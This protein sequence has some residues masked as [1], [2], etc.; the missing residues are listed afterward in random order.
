VYSVAQVACEAR[1]ARS[2]CGG[3]VLV[4]CVCVCVCVF[5]RYLT[6]SCDARQLQLA[7]LGE[8]GLPEIVDVLGP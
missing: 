7:A 5:Q 1:T 3:N 6:S 4:F 8:G 2:V